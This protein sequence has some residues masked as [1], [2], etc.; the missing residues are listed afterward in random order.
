MRRLCVGC[1]I[2][3]VFSGTATAQHLTTSTANSSATEE[4]RARP[5]FIQS[6][7]DDPTAATSQILERLP[8][9]R[10]QELLKKNVALRVVEAAVGAMIVGYQLGHADA[11]SPMAQV[12]VH[13]IRYS[14][15]E[16]LEGSRFRVEPQLVRGGFAICV[17]KN[18]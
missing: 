10:L 16:W 18:N 4:S 3:L 7:S 17:K 8:L 9:D 2:V 11:D 5:L 1:G 12:G 14:G 6:R 13:A 15:A